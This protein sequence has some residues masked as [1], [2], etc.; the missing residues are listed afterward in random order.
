MLDGVL[1]DSLANAEIHSYWSL[2][3]AIVSMIGV[4]LAAAAVHRYF[5]DR[6]R[7]EARG[8]FFPEP[9]SPPPPPPRRGFEVVFKEEFYPAP[10]V[11]A[12]RAVPRRRMSSAPPSTAS[13]AAEGSGTGA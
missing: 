3:F 4:M 7:R 8:P 1:L 11:P 9:R 5:D 2:F 13:A 6:W 12:R 10:T